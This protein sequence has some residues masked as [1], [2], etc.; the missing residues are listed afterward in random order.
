MGCDNVPS[1]QA[2]GTMGQIVSYS[3]YILQ[4]GIL[5]HYMVS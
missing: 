4:Q 1:E 3:P 5:C 2:N